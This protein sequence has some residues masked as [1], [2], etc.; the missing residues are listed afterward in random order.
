M[1]CDEVM[2]NTKEIRS[3]VLASIELCLSGGISWSVGRLVGQSVGWSVDRLVNQLG[4]QSL[5]QSF[6]YSV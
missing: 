6:S 1:P 2:L 4:S 3:V 5:G